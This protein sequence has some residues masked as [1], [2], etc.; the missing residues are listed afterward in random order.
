MVQRGSQS[1]PQ[2]ASGLIRQSPGRETRGMP[3]LPTFKAF[4]IPLVN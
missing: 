4:K 1:R 3:P 2:G